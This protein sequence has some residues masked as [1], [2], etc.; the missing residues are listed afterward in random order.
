MINLNCQTIASMVFAQN[1]HVN[2]LGGPKN[3]KHNC[4]KWNATCDQCGTFMFA[5]RDNKMPNNVTS[6]GNATRLNEFA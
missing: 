3:T 1:K 2:K 4:G 5:S 6:V